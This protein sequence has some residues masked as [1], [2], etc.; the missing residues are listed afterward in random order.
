MT[1]T[2]TTP[3]FVEQK[4]ILKNNAEWQPEFYGFSDTRS[5]HESLTLTDS[6]FFKNRI[7]QLPIDTGNFWKGVVPVNNLDWVFPDIE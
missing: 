6:I 2:F 4:F 1:K 3:D 7:R 5:L